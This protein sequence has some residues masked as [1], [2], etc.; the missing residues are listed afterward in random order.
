VLDTAV[1]NAMDLPFPDR[2]LLPAVQDEEY[3]EYEEN[4]E[5]EEYEE[6]EDLMETE[7]SDVEEVM[8]HLC[9]DDV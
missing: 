2:I 5:Y 6:D 7:Q 1:V 3:E 8:D 9:E 4:E